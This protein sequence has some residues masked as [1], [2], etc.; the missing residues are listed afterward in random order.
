MSEHRVRLSTEDIELI[1]RALSARAAM[2]K[3]PRRHR[4]ER[5]TARLAEGGR[6]NPKWRLD[7]Q[8]QTHE[9]DLDDDGE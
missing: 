4:I 9:S 7:E 5:L 1:V 8:G 6:G 2:T 3:G